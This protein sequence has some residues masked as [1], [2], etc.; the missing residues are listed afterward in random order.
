V[1]LL[2]FILLLPESPRW[3]AEKGRFDEARTTLARLHA[4][5]DINDTF[6]IAQMED[7]KADI[8]KSKDIGEAT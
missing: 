3:L 4:Q 8:N 2:L 5:G 7:I 1:P 6:V